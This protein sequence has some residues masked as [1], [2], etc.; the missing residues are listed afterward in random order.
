MAFPHLL[1]GDALGYSYKP[2][3]GT[4]EPGLFTGMLLPAW[5]GNHP[6]MAE[7][8]QVLSEFFGYQKIECFTGNFHY[9]NCHLGYIYICNFQTHAGDWILIIYPD[10]AIFKHHFLIFFCIWLVL[11]KTFLF[12][13]LFG[14]LIQLTTLFWRMGWK[15]PP[16][17]FVYRFKFI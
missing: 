11:S 10:L 12:S 14:L 15:H 3:I 16:E 8:F 2:S 9:T 13:I 5:G 1:F 6:Q 4:C 17:P 7:L